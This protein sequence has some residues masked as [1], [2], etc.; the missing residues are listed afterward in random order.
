M[1]T[2]N[3]STD[4]IAAA[5]ALLATMGISSTDLADA[6]STGRVMPTFAEYVPVALKAA[7][8]SSAATWK[9]YLKKLADEWPARPIDEP[10]ATEIVNLSIKIQQ[11][12][13]AGR[14]YRGGIGARS[15]F[16]DAIR[17]FY[18]CAM[19]DNL[20]SAHENPVRNVKKPARPPRNR[21]ALT[22]PQLAEINDAVSTEGR[23]PAL[24]SLVLRLH[25]ETACR[26]G[27]AI[28]LRPRDLETTQLTV[29][30]REKG[31][32]VRDQPVSPTLMA[33]LLAHIK[34]R[35]PDADPDSPLLRRANRRPIDDNYY[36]LL[37]ERT[38][39]SVPWVKN[40]GVTAHWLRYT[41]LT[42]VE[43]NFGYAV[44]AGYAGHVPVGN[45]AGNTLTYVAAT[46]EEIATA[47][48]ALTGEP[49]PL[50]LT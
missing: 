20:V 40:L 33:S 5:K 2:E 44:A 16:I 45:R 12:S 21:R 19:A 22:P 6:D 50:A 11:R 41:T 7:S 46:I 29:R 18:R 8:P 26:R 37:W 25:T 14:G 38:G 4:T 10:T 24:D 30:L 48:A 47:L 15:N 23:D 35:A 31:N 13:A 32:S 49:H 39:K 28:A 36:H 27:G 17:F 43:R 34:H 42:W 9:I 1:A 3:I